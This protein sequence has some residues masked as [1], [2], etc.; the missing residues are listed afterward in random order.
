MH[1]SVVVDCPKEELQEVA[2][3]T[4]KIMENLP[5]PWLT[6]DWIDG[7]PR[8]YPIEADIEIGA[9]YNDMAGYDPEEF[10]TFKSVKGYTKYHLDQSYVKDHVS[11]GLLDKD[12]GDLALEKIKS[13]KPAYQEM[14]GDSW[15]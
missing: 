9:T 15:D 12:K 8:R 2:M 5:V 1:D 14:E 13:A 10:K 11:N 4:K 3:M 7:T 6:V